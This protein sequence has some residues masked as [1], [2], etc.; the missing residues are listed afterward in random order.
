MELKSHF[1]F[2]KKQRSGIVFLLFLII[3]LLCVYWLVDFSEEDVLDLSSAEIVATQKELDS[4]RLVEIDN[5]KP[6]TYPFNPNYITDYRGYVLGMSNE[7]I[8]RLLQFRK[9]GNWVNSATD[10][11]KVTGVSDSLLAVLSPYFK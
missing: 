1:T 2:K 4:L 9:E 5:R 3:F 11:Q 10:F 7:E 8:D 6:K